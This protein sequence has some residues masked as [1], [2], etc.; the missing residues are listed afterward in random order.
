VMN[1]EGYSENDELKE[2]VMKRHVEIRTSR[3]GD[4][5]NALD[6]L[7]H[8]PDLADQLEENII[9]HKFN[10]KDINECFNTARDFNCL[11]CVV[12]CQNSF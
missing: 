2:A 1:D 12:S 6:L 3:C 11:K 10:L 4:F 8:N 9:T 7:E 5:R